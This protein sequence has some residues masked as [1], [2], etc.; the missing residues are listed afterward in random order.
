MH[1]NGIDGNL[2]AGNIRSGVTIMGVAGN[3]TIESL[4]GRQYASG[5][6]P[7]SGTTATFY[8]VYNN[9]S[10][11]MYYL[12]VSGLSFKPTGIIIKSQYGTS[13]YVITYEEPQ[14]IPFGMTC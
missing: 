12:K 13:G 14:K 4:G 5:S 10:T 11:S 3:V 1:I 6:A 8:T 2:I 7:Y 9:N